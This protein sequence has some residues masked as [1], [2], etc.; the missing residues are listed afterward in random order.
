M[1]LSCAH[2]I[3]SHATLLFEFSILWGKLKLV[4]MKWESVYIYIYCENVWK[5]KVRKS[6]G[7]RGLEV[8]EEMQEGPACKVC[9][10][11]Y[12]NP[13]DPSYLQL[14]LHLISPQD[15]LFF[16]YNRTYSTFSFFKYKRMGK[17][18]HPLIQ[19]FHLYS[20]FIFIFSTMNEPTINNILYWVN[21]YFRAIISKPYKRGKSH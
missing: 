7:S 17:F 20:I 9:Q 13:M 21:L 14:I 12:N 19:L 11:A 4:G 2:F 10:Y 6:G 5:H 18:T 8:S 15:H 16:S 3:L 1:L